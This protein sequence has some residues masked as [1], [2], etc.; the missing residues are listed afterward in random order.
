VWSCWRK[1]VCRDSFCK[2]REVDL[3]DRFGGVREVRESARLFCE[4]EGEAREQRSAQCWQ[5]EVGGVRFVESG[6]A[7][8]VAG[9]WAYDDSKYFCLVGLQG[10][11]AS[12]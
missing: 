8:R 3:C 7:S 2:G 9:D 6:E 1:P 12:H 4:G 5:Q 10:D 11:S